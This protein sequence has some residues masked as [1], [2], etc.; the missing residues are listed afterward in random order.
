MDGALSFPDSRVGSGQNRDESSHSGLQYETDDQHHGCSGADGGNQS[1]NQTFLLPDQQRIIS[2][3]FVIFWHDG[4]EGKVNPKL[5]AG[6]YTVWAE[7]SHLPARRKRPDCGLGGA[8]AEPLNSFGRS[9][10][11]SGQS[12]PV[13]HD[14]YQYR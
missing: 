11:E 12:F 6:F 8:V 5:E 2:A 14:I 10:N 3:E 1:L 4:L 7:L 9:R 13:M